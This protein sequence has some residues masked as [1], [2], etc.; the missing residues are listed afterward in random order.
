[1][2]P[3]LVG[4]FIARTAQLSATYTLAG[5]RVSGGRP[6][7][8]GVDDPQG[9]EMPTYAI[10]YSAVP[11][12]LFPRPGRVPFRSQNIQVDCYGPDLRTAGVLY[13]QFYADF[14]PADNATPSGWIAGKCAVSSIEEISSPAALFGGENVWPRWTTTLLVKFVE[15][16]VPVMQPVVASASI[17]STTGI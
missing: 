14:F 15:L 10:V 17:G 1:M 11:G 8:K 4:A 3:D 5:G 13:Q 9:W 7:I 2:L 16:R 12:P 6:R